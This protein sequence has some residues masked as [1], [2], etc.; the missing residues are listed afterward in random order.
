MQ[1]YIN[2]N[3]N[4]IALSV[5]E[6]DQTEWRLAN[7]SDQGRIYNLELHYLKVPIRQK[8]LNDSN[9]LLESQIAFN[10]NSYYTTNRATANITGQIT[11]INGKILD[12][13]Y[14]FSNTFEKFIE[15]I[16]SGLSASEALNSVL[17]NGVSI[18]DS[19]VNNSNSLKNLYNQNIVWLTTNEQPAQFTIQEFGNLGDTI[20]QRNQSIYAQRALFLHQLESITNKEDLQSFT[21]EFVL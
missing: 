15:K 13:H 20:A 5:I 8:I 18:Y 3:T 10:D 14:N 1:Y 12:Y 4:E 21:Y 2:I 11:L 16:A 6:L 7:E 9:V 17:D 19:F